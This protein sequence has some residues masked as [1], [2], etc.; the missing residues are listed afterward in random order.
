MLR[1]RTAA[2]SQER[3][4][5][6][7]AAQAQVPQSDA[8]GDLVARAQGGDARAFE[9]LYRTHVD[10]VYALCLR[11]SADRAR[12]ERL[13]QDTFVRCWE[14]LGTFRGESRFSSW[15][16]R[17]AVNVVLNDQ[18]ARKRRHLRLESTGDLGQYGRPVPDGIA[19]ETIDVERAL[20]SLPEA[21]RTVLVLYGIEG[22]K[23][24][25]IAEITGL[26]EG[27][28]KA[29]IHR[30]RKLIQKTLRAGEEETAE[31]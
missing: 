27:T 1:E 8:D 21:A 11:M 18:R 19:E 12:A 17:M 16:Y 30:A 25:E 24:R 5:I 26:A 28:V 2:V 31:S 3:D 14:K 10:R 9:E 13:T 6:S 20:A 7:P 29:Q 23:Y 15:L 4:P 22:Y